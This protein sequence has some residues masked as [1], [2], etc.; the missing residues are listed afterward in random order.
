M[1]KVCDVTSPIE[2]EDRYLRYSI[3]VIQD[4]NVDVDMGVGVPN[5]ITFLGQNDAL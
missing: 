5:V 1:K 4:V 3:T 2:A